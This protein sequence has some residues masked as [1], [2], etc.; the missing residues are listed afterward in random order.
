[1]T[2]TRLHDLAALADLPDR[3]RRARLAAEL[4][5]VRLA[6]DEL[7]WDAAGLLARER[8][9]RARFDMEG[10]RVFEAQ[11]MRFEEE[12]NRLMREFGRD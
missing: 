8:A 3:D 4:D 1:M 2:H 9:R 7:A 5:L 11:E 12:V 6:N 10:R